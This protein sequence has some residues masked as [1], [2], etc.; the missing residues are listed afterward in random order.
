MRIL[1][2]LIGLLMFAAS[3]GCSGTASQRY[4]KGVK[5]Y[6][7]VGVLVVAAIDNDFVSLETAIVIGDIDAAAYAEL[8]AMRDALDTNPDLADSHYARFRRIIASLQEITKEPKHGMP[9]PQPPPQPN[10]GGG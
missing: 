10:F 1:S 7:A 6:S 2:V 9:A 8:V 3:T 5:T 4:E